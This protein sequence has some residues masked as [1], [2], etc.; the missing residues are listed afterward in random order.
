MAVGHGWVAVVGGHHRLGGRHIEDVREASSSRWMK[1]RDNFKVKKQAFMCASPTKTLGIRDKYDGNWLAF[2]TSAT[3]S[4]GS[5]SA[6]SR[7]AHDDMMTARHRRNTRMECGT[8]EAMIG[9]SH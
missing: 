2:Y 6:H 3:S 9:A 4:Q 1:V 7:S 5:P 8:V